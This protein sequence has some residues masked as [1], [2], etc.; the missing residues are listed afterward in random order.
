MKTMV[1]QQHRQWR[2]RLTPVTGELRGPRKAGTL[3]IAQSH[4]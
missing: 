4:Q 1:A 2:A 3:A